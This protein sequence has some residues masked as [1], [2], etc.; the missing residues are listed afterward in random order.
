MSHQEDVKTS[1]GQ[2]NPLDLAFG[3]NVFAMYL[4]ISLKY[5]TFRLTGHS[6]EDVVN[7]ERKMGCHW[8]QN[9]KTSCKYKCNSLTWTDINM[10]VLE[11]MA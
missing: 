7:S 9:L 2:V 10:Q 4:F 6:I 5:H 8:R 3:P 11:I 1:P